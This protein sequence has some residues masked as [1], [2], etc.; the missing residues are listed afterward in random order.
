MLEH[1]N[2]G[3]RMP[4]RVA[5][6][7]AQG[8]V[9]RASTRLLAAEGVPVLALGRAEADL[10]AAGAASRLSRSRTGPVS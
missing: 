7:G 8:F 3:A 5:I 2:S 10:L 1:L 4:R 9:G 6:L